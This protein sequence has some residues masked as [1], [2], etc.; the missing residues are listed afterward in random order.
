MGPTRK[1][2]GK[3]GAAIITTVMASL[4]IAG[5]ASAA[6]TGDVTVSAESVATIELTLSSDTAAFGTV[7][8]D[9]TTSSTGVT[10]I[11]DGAGSGACYEWPGSV[12]VSSNVLYDVTV[13]AN[14]TKPKL[15]FLT[16]NPSTFAACT[17]GEGVSADPDPVMF[18][19][20]TP[21]G[22]WA[23]DQA[24]TASEAHPYH[25]GLE[26]LWIDGPSTT[27]ASAILTL[28]AQAG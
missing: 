22:G 7:S 27:L 18:A 8:P 6:T 19:S 13:S 16:T 20:A 24:A 11:E 1:P 26:V 4:A 21:A 12:T 23:L 17:G 9:G 10:A 2:L 3:V 5:P 14:T 15:D 25:L 28:T